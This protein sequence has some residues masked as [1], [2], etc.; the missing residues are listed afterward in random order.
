MDLL[1]TGNIIYASETSEESGKSHSA[2]S[3]IK[4]ADATVDVTAGVT[5]IKPEHFARQ[6][7]YLIKNG[8]FINPYTTMTK[9]PGAYW[10][11]E[12]NWSPDGPIWWP[13]SYSKGEYFYNDNLKSMCFKIIGSESNN[14]AHIGGY[15]FNSQVN[16]DNIKT[17]TMDFFIY[18]PYPEQHQGFT[19][20]SPIF[21]VGIVSELYKF[22]E[23]NGYYDTYSFWDGP[24]LKAA[25]TNSTSLRG[26]NFDGNLRENGPYPLDT[27]SL[28]LSGNHTVTVTG[29]SWG[30]SFYLC[31][32]N[33]KLTY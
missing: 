10:D 5:L 3:V 33:L 29:T 11:P 28:A 30:D 21:K 7:I 17:M 4:V 25:I 26:R 22:E 12:G 20:N 32:K 16:L 24:N 27:G 15:F 13:E 8:Q 2:G 23:D 18:T 9:L 19:E 14:Y 6:E 1:Q 31:I